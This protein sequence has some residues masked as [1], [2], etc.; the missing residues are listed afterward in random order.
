M[1]PKPLFLLRIAIVLAIALRI[2]LILVLANLSRPNVFRVDDSITYTT[3]AQSLA[4]RGAFLDGQSRP[5]IFRTPGYPLV[6]APFMALHASDA[7]I[8]AINIVFAVL[9]VIVTWKIARHVFGDDRVA[10]I[11][12]LIVAVEPTMLLWSLKVMPE[13][14]FT[15]CLVLFAY[16]AVREKPIAAAV[17]L[18]AAI[19]VKP[20]LRFYFP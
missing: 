12:A 11:C 19:Y 4:F 18:C 20:L 15:L 10:G 16:A 5:E 6:L 9:A 2:S 7:L 14:L 3:G 17:A 13:T 8:V 1:P